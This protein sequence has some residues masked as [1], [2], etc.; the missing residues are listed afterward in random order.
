MKTVAEVAGNDVAFIPATGAL[1]LTDTMTLTAAAQDLGADAALVITPYYARPTQQGLFE[2]YAMIAREFPDL[3]LVLYNVPSRTAV[4]LHPSTVLRLRRDC[5]NIVG[6]KETTREF[7]HFSHVMHL[8]G[9]DFLVWSGIELLALPLLALGGAGFI[10]AL[11]NLAPRSLAEM[12]EHWEAGRVAQARDIHFQLHPLADLLFVETNPAPAKWVLQR[13]G[14]LPSDRVR[15]PLSQLSD[16][17]R[18]SVQ[19]LLDQAQAALE[20]ENPVREPA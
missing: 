20:R 3:P 16:T 10:S 17:G 2:W 4:D 12:Y 15:P 6:I 19:R 7:E 8:C 1:S 11:T 14:R 18:E 9:Q 5:G 13:Q